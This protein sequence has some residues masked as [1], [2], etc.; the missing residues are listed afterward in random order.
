M[1]MGPTKKKVMVAGFVGF[2]L[3]VV[4][5]VLL[6]MGYRS[7]MEEKIKELEIKTVTETRYVTSRDIGAGEVLTAEDVIPVEVKGESAPEDSFAESRLGDIIN[8]RTVVNINQKTILTD[9]M[10]LPEAD[11]TPSKDIR[12]QE[13]NMIT[14]PSDL[15]AGDYID[16]RFVTPNGENYIVTS[17]KEV[18]KLGIG[19][20]TNTVFLRLDEEDILRTTAAVIESYILNGSEVYATKYVKPST[21]L[22]E[23]S[24]VDLIELYDK[25]Y[26]QIK[27]EKQEALLKEMEGDTFGR[28][29]SSDISL[30]VNT[31]ETFTLGDITLT[32]TPTPTPTPTSSLAL[33]SSGENPDLLNIS[34]SDEEIAAR[35]GVDYKVIEDMKVA[36]NSRDESK[37]AYYQNWLLKKNTSMVENYPVNEKIAALIAHNPNILRDLSAKYDIEKLEAE[38]EGFANFPLYEV[39][40]YGDVKE[41]E[42]V[43]KIQAGITTK[44]E[45]QKNERKQYL[46]SLLINNY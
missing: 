9:S 26:E 28:N 10:L 30:I 29:N 33:T 5:G 37:I 42:A 4:V 39:D 6:F 21:Q 13:F 2:L 16:I 7:K 34:V 31:E 8:R 12:L 25:T 22:V 19:N 36:R 44:I 38:R 27:Q 35:I 43:G 45:T 18:E 1:M 24:R 41:L 17:G 23:S 46:Q 14:L 40:T 15:N 11:Q 3:P 32:T 20:D